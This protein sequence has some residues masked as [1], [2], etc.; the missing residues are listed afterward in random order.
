MFDL[1]GLSIP[2]AQVRLERPAEQLRQDF[3]A[4]LGDGGVVAALGQLVAD[5]GVLRPRELVEAEDGARLAQLVPDQVPPLVRDVRVLEAEDHR[6]LALDLPQP[7]ERVVAARHRLGRHIGSRVRP[8]RSAVHV[9][10]E[11]GHAGR[12]SRIQLLIRRKNHFS[13]GVL[14]SFHAKR[15]KGSGLTLARRER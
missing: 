6:H 15:R 5:E 2:G 4:D 10:C 11:V 8:E 14:V 12:N 3:E 7:V 13:A 1:L 9:R